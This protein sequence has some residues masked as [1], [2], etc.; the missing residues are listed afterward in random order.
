MIR[1]G[2]AT[3]A[4]LIFTFGPHFR[5][6]AEH[7]QS[8]LQGKLILGWLEKIVLKPWD[9][10]LRAKLDT[11]AN[12]ASID[13]TDIAFF[14]KDGQTWVRFAIIKNR[15]NDKPNHR[16][17]IERP[18]V[19]TVLIREHFWESQQRPVVSLEFCLSGTLFEAE[20]NL[21]DRT[22]FTYPV[23]LGR[24]FL[25]KIALVDPEATLLT[26]TILRDCKPSGIGIA[27]NDEHGNRENPE[28]PSKTA[29]PN[30]SVAAEVQVHQPLGPE[31]QGE[32][33]R[34]AE[35]SPGIGIDTNGGPGK[36]GQNGTEFSQSVQRKKPEVLTAAPNESATLELR[37]TTRDPLAT[38][39]E[40]LD[41]PDDETGKM[42]RN[43]NPL[44]EF[45]PDHEPDGMEPP[46]IEA[47]AQ[48]PERLAKK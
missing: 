15:R 5:A 41:E 40:I 2:I 33:E 32:V 36:V 43:T 45:L 9:V 16:I 26:H 30:E 47:L 10:V 17:E 38:G 14:E 19:R 20:F 48:E 25:Q 27:A 31:P 28:Q 1:I 7:M 11:G 42:P 8:E 44:A 29:H 46:V 24:R 23:L 39:P 3:L 37:P 6:E 18:L 21:V 12:T 22:N 34:L 13:A 4:G 35:Q